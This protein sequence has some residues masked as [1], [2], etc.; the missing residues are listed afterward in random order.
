MLIGHEVG[1]L[2]GELGDGV[3]IDGGATAADGLLDEG[4]VE[5]VEGLDV[6]AQLFT[7][8][9]D[10]GVVDVFIVFGCAAGQAPDVGP[11]LAVGASMDEEVAAVA[12]GDEAA[13]TDEGAPWIVVGGHG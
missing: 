8:F 13:A 2:A 7:Q 1:R 11:G 3:D 6:D 9:A 10:E 4:G 12:V 5:E